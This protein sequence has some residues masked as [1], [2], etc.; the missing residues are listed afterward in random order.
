M[1]MRTLG[2]KQIVD[3][4][5]LVDKN[6]SVEQGHEIAQKVQD[7]LISHYEDIIEVMVHVEPKQ[8]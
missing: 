1:R 5:I 4:E 8:D 2:S 7:K 6:L 3:I